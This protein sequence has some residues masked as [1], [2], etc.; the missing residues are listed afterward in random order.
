MEQPPGYVA[1][2]ESSEVCLLK[3]AIYG[4]KQS[5][6]AWF[7]KFSQLLFSYGFVSTV[8]DP[9]VMR[10]RTP[11]GCV[12]LAVY[13]DEII[14]TGSDDAEV[15]ATKAYLAQHFVTR[16]LSPPRYF[17]GL[18]ITYRQGHMSICQRKYV[19]DLLDETGTLGCKPACSPM[20][21][22]VD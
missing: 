3:K 14:I 4:L 10:K 13:V 19:L 22:N 21:Q 6:C 1:Q 9:T 17:L 5:P 16:D 7:H 8:S 12:I 15:D 20:E 18:E 11:H 2:G